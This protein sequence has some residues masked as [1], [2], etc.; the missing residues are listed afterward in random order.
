MSSR[1]GAWCISLVVLL[2]LASTDCFRR[3]RYWRARPSLGRALV[4]AA[5]LSAAI[6]GTAAVMAAHDAHF[7]SE[8]CGHHRRFHDGR[9]VYYYNNHWEYHDGNQWYSY[10][11]PPPD[12]APPPTAPPPGEY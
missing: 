7:H 3:G 4:G 11:T 9:W 5:I 1:V 2:G 6:V 10:P 12:A 8:A